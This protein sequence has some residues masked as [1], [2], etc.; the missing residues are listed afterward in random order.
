MPF[1]KNGHY[2]WPSPSHSKNSTKNTKNKFINDS[3]VGSNTKEA[4]NVELLLDQEKSKQNGSEHT[5]NAVLSKTINN[6]ERVGEGK[7]YAPLSVPKLASPTLSPV[8]SCA[9]VSKR[10][11]HSPRS[12]VNTV[13]ASRT[14]L[15]P[16]APKLIDKPTHL[17]PLNSTVSSFQKHASRNQKSLN[18]SKPSIGLDL[19]PNPTCS[20]TS[21]LP[22]TKHSLSSPSFLTTTSNVQR[23]HRQLAPKPLTG[24]SAYTSLSSVF[25]NTFGSSSSTTGISSSI[26]PNTGP[27]V[28]P[29]ST[30]TNNNTSI[31]SNISSFE[32]SPN[33]SLSTTSSSAPKLS[34]LPTPF[35]PIAPKTIIE[36]AFLKNHQLITSL[37]LHCDDTN[38]IYS[39]PLAPHIVSKSVLSKN[40]SGKASKHKTN[41]SSVIPSAARNN[42]SAVKH[43]VNTINTDT[44]T[45]SNR[46]SKKPNFVAIRPRLLS[47]SCSKNLSSKNPS[48]Q[49]KKVSQNVSRNTSKSDFQS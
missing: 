47:K 34:L 37:G 43:A 40:E 13:P 36:P 31:T 11:A 33:H 49:I 22:V 25:K 39:K 19:T 7:P 15:I 42:V 4:K 48:I 6:A 12:I 38:N 3:F 10:P 17:K 45:S 29:N 23:K 30:S 2:P 1:S 27:I 46:K 5:D 28:S 44:S 14:R 32:N 8:R 20:S 41:T 9:K 16:I 35:K 24:K 18:L 21:V 26:P